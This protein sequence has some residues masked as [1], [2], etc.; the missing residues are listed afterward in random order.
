MT[1][2]RHVIGSSSLVARD[3]FDPFRHAEN[4]R[5]DKPSAAY[6]VS[7]RSVRKLM[8]VTYPAANNASVSRS[9]YNARLFIPALSLLPDTPLVT[10]PRKS[11]QSAWARDFRL[12]RRIRLP[13]CIL[14][15][16]SNFVLFSIVFPRHENPRAKWGF[17]SR[18]RA[19]FHLRYGSTLGRKWHP[20]VAARGWASR[21]EDQYHREGEKTSRL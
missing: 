14:L 20:N 3:K 1:R 12:P 16:K 4:P 18:L 13:F 9:A 5:D 11:H 8:H 2:C 15:K 17:R 7:Y 21:Q 6:R 10:I 19:R